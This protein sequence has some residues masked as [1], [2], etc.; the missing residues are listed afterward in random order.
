MNVT[1]AIDRGTTPACPTGEPC[2]PQIVAY[3]LVFSRPGQPDV[4]VRPGP[5]GTF[6]LHLDPGSYTIV[7]QPP[8]ARGRLD[9]SNVRVPESG[10]VVLH[11]R[12]TAG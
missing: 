6:V 8:L 2:D 5:D 11:L 1:G 10:T 3:R 4:T 12:I 7:A 9:P